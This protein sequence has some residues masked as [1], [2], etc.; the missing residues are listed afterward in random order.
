MIL[1]NLRV[2]PTGNNYKISIYHAVISLVLRDKR[3]HVCGHILTHFRQAS[4]L[5]TLKVS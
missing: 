2:D 4:T 5:I 1:N 3:G